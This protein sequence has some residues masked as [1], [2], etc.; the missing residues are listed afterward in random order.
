MMKNSLPLVI[1]V[2]LVVLLGVGLKLD[3]REVPSPLIDKPAPD[4][5]LSD[6]HNTNNVITPEAMKGRVWL[7]NV[8]AS[9]CGACRAEHQVINRL[10]KEHHVEIVGLNYKD[11]SYDAKQWLEDFGN[12]Y[13]RVAIDRDGR[14]GID[15]GVYGV[16]ETFVVDKKGIIR[17]KSIGPVDQEKLDE[18]I[19]PLIAQLNLEPLS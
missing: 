6:L 3:P 19:L 1:F 13:A 16:P 4:F 7:L 10:V 2:L 5:Q 14:T 18:I 8:W 11:A 9:W 17:Y 12:P 15:W